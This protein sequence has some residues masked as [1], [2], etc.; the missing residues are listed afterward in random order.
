MPPAATSGPAATRTMVTTPQSTAALAVPPDLPA[1]QIP[2]W[3]AWRK[4]PHADTYGLEKGPNTYCARCHAPANYDAQAKVDA[5]PNCVSCK[6]PTDTQVRLAEHNQ[7]IAQG[8][9]RSIGCDI[10]HQAGAKG[11]VLATVAWRDPATRQYQPIA[12]ATE[13]CSKCHADTDTL[14][15]RRDLGQAAH[16]GFSCVGCH[17][18]HSMAA[19]CTAAACHPAAAAHNATTP[20]HDPKHGKVDCVACHDA[21]GLQVGRVKDTG[22]WTTWRTTELLGRKTTAQYKSHALQRAVNCARCHFPGNS[23][24]LPENVSAKP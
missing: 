10:C 9:W 17:D 24:G 22:N 8:D 14:R 2:F 1:D 18:A 19:S 13:L 21:A 7:F 15:H 5:P 4:G 12:T 11:G 16:K 20:G 3:L 6:F 23:F